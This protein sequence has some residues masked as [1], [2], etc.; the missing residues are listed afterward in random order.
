MTYRG[1][2]YA[3]ELF[4]STKLGQG[5]AIKSVQFVCFDFLRP[6]QQVFSHVGTGL[7]KQRIECRLKDTEQCLSPFKGVC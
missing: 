3:R 1:D 7:T 5:H 4:T 2:S 6:S